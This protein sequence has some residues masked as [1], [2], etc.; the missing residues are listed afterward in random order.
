MTLTLASAIEGALDLLFP[1]GAQDETVNLSE[2]DVLKRR[3]I[4]ESSPHSGTPLH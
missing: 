2:L 4:W 3:M 1:K